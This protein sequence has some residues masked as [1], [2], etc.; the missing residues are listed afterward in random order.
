MP[1]LHIVRTR[2]KKKNVS[3]KKG[4]K[5][6]KTKEKKKKRKKR[7]KVFPRVEFSLT[8]H[9]SC[10]D[11]VGRKSSHMPLETIR[12]LMETS[13]ISFPKHRR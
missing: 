3:I 4:N 6:S 2:R 11:V 9:M 10:P 5:G 13:V 7:K 1:F 12:K 8:L